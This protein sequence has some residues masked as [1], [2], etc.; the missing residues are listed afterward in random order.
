MPGRFVDTNVL[1]YAISPDPEEE[2]KAAAARAVLEDPRLCLSVQVLQE[3]CVQVTRPS[4][5]GR[6]GPAE[7]AGLVESFLRFHVQE[8]TRSVVLAA[9]AT[10]RRFT[11]PYWDAAIIEAA[12]SAGCTTVL[13]EDLSHGADYD[14]VQVEDPFRRL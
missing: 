5:P 8:T 2:L 12:R 13:S 4:R 6:L 9:M 14:G 3:F 1:I 11:I 10:A 7:A